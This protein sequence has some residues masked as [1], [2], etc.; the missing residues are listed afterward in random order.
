K[1]VLNV[2]DEPGAVSVVA[3]NGCIVELE[4]VD[5]ACLLG[6]IAALGCER[7]GLELEGQ[8]DVQ[9][10][11]AG[12]TKHSD[13]R[14]ETVAW[15]E[16]RFVTQ[17]LFELPREFGV[18]ARRLGLRD[19]VADHGVEIGHRRVGLRCRALLRKLREQSL[20]LYADTLCTLDRG[21]GLRERQHRDF[22]RQGQLRWQCA[23]DAHQVQPAVAR[24]ESL[25]SRLMEQ[26]L[27]IARTLGRRIAKLRVMQ[28]LLRYPA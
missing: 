19:R 26:R 3:E 17:I 12:G 5:R 20:G 25:C 22:E 15:R 9:A 11:T 2:A 6:A 10:L 4:R 16:N 27:G 21:Y 14:S 23:Q 24:H 1:P 28:A 13:G 7:E 8:R 18:N